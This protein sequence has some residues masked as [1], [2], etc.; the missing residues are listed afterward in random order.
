MVEIRRDQW[1]K[2]MDCDQP[3]RPSRE[4]NEALADGVI[5][6]A[7]A[8][9]DAAEQRAIADAKADAS[10]VWALADFYLPPDMREWTAR[11]ELTAHAWRTAFV[12]GWRA[13]NRFLQAE[14]NGG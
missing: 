5:D 10:A 7:L 6:A 13:A 12:A 2:L 14:K 8:S 11:T 4:R 9:A 1:F 3:A